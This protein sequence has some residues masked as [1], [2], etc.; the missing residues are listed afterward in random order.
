MS[1]PLFFLVAFFGCFFIPSCSRESEDQGT[2]E[3]GKSSSP[4]MFNSN[5]IDEAVNPFQSGDSNYTANLSST[6]LISVDQATFSEAIDINENGQCFSKQ[7]GEVIEGRYRIVS[8]SGSVLSTSSFR[9][10][11][12][13]GARVDYHENGV[14]SISSTY[15]YGKK[16]GK[17]EWRSEKGIKTYEANF[18]DDLIDG[19]ETTWNEDGQVVSKSRFEKGK[20]VEQLI[21]RGIGVSK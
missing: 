19:I 21:E 10:G 17:E 1:S 9:N 11:F 16:N 7:T 14:A 2:E 15:L 6:V 8:Q 20:L 4:S 13:H 3:K 18:R 5:L 12:Y